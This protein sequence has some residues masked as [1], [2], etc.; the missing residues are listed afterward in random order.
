MNKAENKKQKDDA[1]HHKEYNIVVNGSNKTWN[2][3][4]I[5]FEQVVILAFGKI[6]PNVRYTMTYTRGHGNKPGGTMVPGDL[7]KVKKGMI[8]NVTPTNKS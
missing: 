4:E 3:K 8:F 5:T 6:D 7:V 2:E 1:E